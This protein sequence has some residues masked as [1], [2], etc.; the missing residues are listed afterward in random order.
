MNLVLLEKIHW[1]TP[2]NIYPRITQVAIGK[3]KEI[4]I[5]G[6]DWPTPDGTGIRDYIHVID[7]S[8]R[9]FCSI[10]LFIKRKTSNINFKSWNRVKEQV[11]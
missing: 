10:K 2:N 3:I 1:E 6:S 8:R 4:K 9:T 7:L 11:F 5:F